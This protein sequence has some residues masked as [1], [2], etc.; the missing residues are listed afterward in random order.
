MNKKLHVVYLYFE[1]QIKKNNLDIGQKPYRISFI[2]FALNY[3]H[4]KS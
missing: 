1:F 4:W 3:K 2:F